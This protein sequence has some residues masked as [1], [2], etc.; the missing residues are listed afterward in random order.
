MSEQHVHESVQHCFVLFM[1]NSALARPGTNRNMKKPPAPVSERPLDYGKVASEL[2]RA[3]RGSKR[4]RPGFSRHL[5]YKSNIAQRWETGLAWPTAESFFAVCVRLRVDVKAALATFMRR[6]PPWLAGASLAELP[7]ALL[8]ELRGKTRLSAI[9]PR[10][11]YHRSSVSRWVGGS[12]K[13]KLPELLCL[14]DALSGRALDFVAAFVDPTKLP[15]I[16]PRWQ[17]LA[18]S[19]EL[20]YRHPMSHAVLHAL[21]LRAY[22]TEGHRDPEFLTRAVGLPR[23]EVERAL[24]LLEESGQV[25]RTR[26]GFRPAPEAVVDTGA[27]PERARGL[28]ITF[29]ELAVRRLRGGA[30]G[31]CGYTLFAVSR[32][33]LRRLRD[34]H[35]AYVRDMQAVIT[36]SA[37]SE[38]V[39]LY[40][41][42]LLD[43]SGAEIA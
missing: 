37:P 43:L 26:Q 10:T 17:K 3:L 36:A 9:A 34:I 38:C 29:A 7:N 33:D 19:R 11:P 42:Q 12:S 25:R 18:L 30:P 35:L 31:Q 4:S 2:L 13:P 24:T 1:L 28:R 40:A 32:A 22:A 41:A 20:A 27:D 21:E 5:G 8:G 14:I 15:S 39:A 23:E 16:A 6:S